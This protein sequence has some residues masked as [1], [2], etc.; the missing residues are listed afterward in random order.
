VL[1]DAFEVTAIETQPPFRRE[2]VRLFED[3]AAP[4]AGQQVK[5]VGTAGVVS[6]TRRT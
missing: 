5:V 1:A 4:V 6:L 2:D 3:P